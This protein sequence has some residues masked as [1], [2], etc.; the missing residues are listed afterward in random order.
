MKFQSLLLLCLTILTACKSNSQHQVL[1]HI[2]TAEEEAAYIWRTLQ[3]IPFF[4]AHNYQVSLPKGAFIEDLKAKS[5]AGNLN[6]EEYGRLE[7][8]VRDSVYR[9]KDYQEGYERIT[10]QLEL[11]DQMI[12]QIKPTDFQWPFKKFE[13]YRVNL[14]LYG[15]GGSFNPE[16][17]SILIYTTPDGRFKN[18]DNPACTIIHEIVHIGIEESIISKFK[19]PHALKERIVDIFVSLHFGE[20]LPTYRI[21]DM[22]EYRIDPFLQQASDFK[23]LDQI[24]E[25]LLKED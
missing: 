20:E 2:P 15:P 22:G 16:E 5:K 1:V 17:G 18:Y 6:S 25:D 13:Q 12:E 10:A 3:D 21:Q 23:Q 9:E 19:V 14:T 7:R 11:V 24:V 4:E 8:Y